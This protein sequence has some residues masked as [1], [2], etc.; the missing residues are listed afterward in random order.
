VI[1][2]VAPTPR[3]TRTKAVVAGVALVVALAVGLVFVT[4]GNGSP[5]RLALATAG[6]DASAETMRLGAPAPAPASADSPGGV[7][8]S[9]YPGWSGMEFRVEGDLPQLGTTAPA[10]KVNGVA[11]DADRFAAL[12][13]ALGLN[14]NAAAGDGGFFL[15]TSDGT[16]SANPGPDGWLVN[17]Y[18]QAAETDGTTRTR[19]AA[20]MSGDEAERLARELL[21]P[22]GAL[23]G[24]W[25]AQR[26]EIETGVGYACAEAVDQKARAAGTGSAGSGSTTP[27]DAVASCPPPPPSVKGWT[28]SFSPVLGDVPSDW[29]ASSVTIAGDRRI[30]SLS[31]TLARFERAGDFELRTVDA[32]LDEVRH[33]G[34]PYPMPMPPVMTGMPPVPMPMPLV[35]DAGEP[36]SAT[37]SAP[38][39]SAGSTPVPAIA[40]TPGPD[41]PCRGDDCGGKPFVT[42]VVVIT[43]VKR[44]LMPIPVYEDAD[45][46]RL[47]LVPAYRFT[48]HFEGGG[49]WETT[50]MA[51]HPDAIAPPPV[52]PGGKP[53]PPPAQT[54]PDGS[55]GSPGAEPGTVAPAKN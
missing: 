37:R 42:P 23:E 19:A 26:S 33:G 45:H 22:L 6:S 35:T 46:M 30:E 31:A 24:Q 38:S 32:A 51:L 25:R 54:E 15:D 29:S 40:P 49:P 20:T 17:F 11:V 28:I 12:A 52:K 7:T 8:R 39:A 44:S 14:G 10:W 4:G 55:A 3:P 5:K 18:R 2:T 27:A 1:E 34:G 13:R 50:V 47:H 43:G 16:L 41:F 21:A 48:G 53:V 9:I 36:A